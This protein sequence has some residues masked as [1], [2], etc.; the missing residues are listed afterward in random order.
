[1]QFWLFNLPA[2]TPL[3]TLV[4]QLLLAAWTGVCP[5]A[6]AFCRDV[7]FG[8]GWPDAEGGEGVVVVEQVAAGLGDVGASGE[9]DGPDRQVADGGQ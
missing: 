6:P 1:M 9:P 2:D 3:P 5:A 7:A 4:L 8:D